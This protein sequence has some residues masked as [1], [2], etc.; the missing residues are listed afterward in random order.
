M[1]R[2]AQNVG[3]NVAAAISFRP[4]RDVILDVTLSFLP[5]F[6]PF[7]GTVLQDIKVWKSHAL[8]ARASRVLVLPSPSGEGP[9]VRWILISREG[10]RG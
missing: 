1:C 3:R 4:V 10:G 8:Q 7:Y 6:R 2:K 5:T 9:G